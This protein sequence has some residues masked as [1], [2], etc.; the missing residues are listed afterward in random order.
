[1]SDPVQTSFPVMGD[2]AITEHVVNI[3]GSRSPYTTMV[4]RQG[5]PAGDDLPSSTGNRSQSVVNAEVLGPCC[6]PQTT[7]F[8]PNAADHDK[9]GRNVKLM[10]SRS[11]VSDFWSERP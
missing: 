2:S 5:V 8:F 4:P 1:M 3:S 6:A 10:P 11:G 9:T 7:L